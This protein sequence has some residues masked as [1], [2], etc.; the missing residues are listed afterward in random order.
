MLRRGIVEQDLGKWDN[1]HQVIAQA[2]RPLLA[3]LCR[4]EAD[5]SRF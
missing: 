5:G 2:H 1:R 4:D 3:A